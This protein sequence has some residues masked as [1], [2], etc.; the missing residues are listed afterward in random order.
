MIE[1]FLSAEEERERYEQSVNNLFDVYINNIHV[2]DIHELTERLVFK[3]NSINKNIIRLQMVRYEPPIHF[4]DEFHNFLDEG[5]I[6]LIEVKNKHTQE[7]V[8]SSTKYTIL[9]TVTA[10]RLG[11]NPMMGPRAVLEFDMKREK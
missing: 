7:L 11:Y 10:T 3:D 4:C 5:S 2:C 8:Y 6:E 9:K 1:E